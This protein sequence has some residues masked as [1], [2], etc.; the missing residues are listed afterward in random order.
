MI[1]AGYYGIT[2]V[3]PLSVH[4]SIYQPVNL[5]MSVC[6]SAHIFRCQAE[7]FR[8]ME[9]WYWHFCVAKCIAR[10]AVHHARQEANKEVHKNIDYIDPKF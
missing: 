6:L 5:L 4:P 10:H 9:D 8:G 7:S 3:V 1:V 2:L